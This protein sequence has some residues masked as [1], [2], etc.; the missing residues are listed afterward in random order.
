MPYKAFKPSDLFQCKKC[1]DCCKGYGGTYV[2]E[3]DIHAI[4]EFL[5]TDEAVFTEKYCR[6]SGKRPVLAQ[7]G[8]GFC[9][10]FDEICTIHPV[11]PRMCRAWPFIEPVLKDVANW[12]IMASVCPGIRTNAP[13]EV[14]RK[15]TRKA[16]KDLYDKTHPLESTTP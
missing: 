13:D 2:T 15:V 6:W 16:L 8:D 3:A 7:A 12:H 10:F 11:K 9:I 4:A 14:I 1:G 5:K